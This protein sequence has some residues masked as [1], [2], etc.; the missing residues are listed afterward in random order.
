MDKV[1]ETKN[2]VVNTL[3]GGVAGLLRSYGVVVHKGIGTITK[4]KNV[5]VNGSELLGNEENHP[6]WWFKSK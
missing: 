2:K 4:D 5:L 6:C 1:L 3:V